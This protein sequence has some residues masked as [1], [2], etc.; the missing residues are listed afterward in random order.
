MQILI[1]NE[2]FVTVSNPAIN[3]VSVLWIDRDIP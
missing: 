3:K 1:I 2:A